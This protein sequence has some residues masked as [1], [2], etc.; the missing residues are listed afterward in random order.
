LT[1]S[2]LANEDYL[3]I[4]A[5]EK[6]VRDLNP[7]MAKLKTLDRRGVIV[8]SRGEKVDFVSRFF[9]PKFGVDED[10]VTGSAHCLLTPY[11]AKKLGISRLTARQISQRGGDL[12]C[13]LKGDRVFISGRAV[14]YMEGEIS[15]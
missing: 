4:Y 14:K 15:I 6:E 7:D 8:S 5:N 1:G 9:A 13:E 11:W 2:R 12:T 3:V 10:P